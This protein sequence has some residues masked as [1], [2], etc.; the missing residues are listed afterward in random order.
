MRQVAVIISA[1]ISASV[2]LGDVGAI[3]GERPFVERL[4]DIQPHDGLADLEILTATVGDCGTPPELLFRRY[5][6]NQGVKV[7]TPITYWTSGYGSPS[8]VAVVIQSQPTNAPLVVIGFWIA[9]VL[10]LFIGKMMALS[11]GTHSLFVLDAQA[12]EAMIG[13]LTERYALINHHSGRFVAT[14][15]Y[16]RQIITSIPPLLWAWLRDKAFSRVGS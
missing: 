16:Y 11:R 4:H 14:K 13:D 9:D 10:L 8:L 1:L 12:R 15:W 7:W 2:S 5:C 3:T 6:P